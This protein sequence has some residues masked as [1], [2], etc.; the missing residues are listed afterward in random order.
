MTIH[1]YDDNDFIDHTYALL[2]GS[3]N[4]RDVKITKDDRI[5]VLQTCNYDP[6]DS[7]VIIIC[8]TV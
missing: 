3:T 4:K 7:L 1:F 2:N 5:L 6:P 8:K